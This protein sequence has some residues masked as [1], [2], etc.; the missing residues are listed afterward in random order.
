MTP[1]PVGFDLDMTLIDSQRAILASFAGVA[2][3]TGVG[4]DPDGVLSRL[5]I[6]LEA[7]LAHWFPPDGI[8]DAVRVYRKHYLQL[9]GP[10]TSALPGAAEALA[11]VRAA[12]ARAVVIT[13]KFELTARLGLEG[14]GLS[15]DEL[16]ADAHGPE[17]GVVLRAIG[18]TVYVGDTPAD[19][20]AAAMAGAH[21]VGV[22]TGSFN[23]AELRAAGA[24][25]VLSS[26]TDFPALYQAIIG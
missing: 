2:A 15:A 12:G 4:I 9:A 6:K 25:D 1:S 14:V 10:L 18:A 21:G 22:T 17:K 26:L 8:E 11:A 24:A 19:M 5:G 16:F 3:D 23:E 20:A 13:A 7:E